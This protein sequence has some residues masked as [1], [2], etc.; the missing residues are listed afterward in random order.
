MKTIDKKWLHE[1]ILLS[2]KCIPVATA[3]CVG[4]VIVDAQ[5]NKI[6]SGYSRET[7]P[8]KHAEEIAI[9][10]AIKV[11]SNLADATLYSSLEP[12]GDRLSGRKTCTERIIETGINRVV[13][14]AH[15]PSTFVTGKGEEI[16]KKAGIEVLFLE[17]GDVIDIQ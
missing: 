15:E 16:L 17:T 3:F 5:G 4:A 10:N 9:E 13:F 6:A 11:K 14:A 7:D 1:A 12:C 8:H 2:K